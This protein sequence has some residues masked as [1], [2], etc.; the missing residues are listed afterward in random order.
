[1][2]YRAGPHGRPLLADNGALVKVRETNSR[3]IS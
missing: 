2:D 3:V 1:M